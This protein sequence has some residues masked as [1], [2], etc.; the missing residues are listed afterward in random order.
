MNKM[1]FDGPVPYVKPAI[2]TLSDRDILEQLG[3][4]QAYTGSLPFSF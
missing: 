3:P 2:E 1:E 4:A